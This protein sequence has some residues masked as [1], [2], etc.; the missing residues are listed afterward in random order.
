MVP[1][2][3]LELTLRPLNAR[4]RR[5]GDVFLFAWS[6]W[7]GVL[8]RLMYSTLRGGREGKGKGQSSSLFHSQLQL[9]TEIEDESI[10][11]SVLLLITH[12]T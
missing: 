1:I 11:Y 8:H 12:C 2:L 5:N 9:Y 6:Q 7:V 4:V 3:W 10:Y